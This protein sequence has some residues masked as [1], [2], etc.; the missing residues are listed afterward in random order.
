M[1]ENAGGDR[2]PRGPGGGQVRELFRVG[3]PTDPLD[4]LCGSSQRQI[5][6]RPDIGSEQSHQQVDVCGPRTNTGK[7]QQDGP[8][9]LITQLGNGSEVEGAGTKGSGDGVTVGRLL[10]GETGCSEA[11]LGG[12]RYMGEG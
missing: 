11:G 10:P 4:L 1:P 7:L 3:K 5:T 2:A 9:C 8:D 6:L 12:G